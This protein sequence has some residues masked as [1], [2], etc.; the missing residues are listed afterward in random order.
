METINF[1]TKSET[2]LATI[3]VNSLD[4]VVKNSNLPVQEADEIKKSYLPFLNQLTETQ[5]QAA[6]INFENPT[7]LDENIAHELRM[8]TVK[9]RTGAEKLKEER[10]KMY[11]LR[12]NLEQASFNLIASSCKIIEEAFFNVE[13]AR[14]I[15]EKKRKEELRRDRSEKLS[16]YIEDVAL[17]PL[18]EMSEEQF[19]NLYSTLRAAHERQIEEERKAESERQRIAAEKAL[20]DERKNSILNFWQFV[21]EDERQSNFGT[22]DQSKWD[23]FCQ[24]LKDKKNAYDA[25]QERIRKDNERLAEEAKKKQ[26]ELEATLKRAKEEQEAK[27]K[28]MAEERRKAEEQRK[29]LEA[30]AAKER[31]EKERLEAELIAKREAEEKAKRDEE[32]RKKEAEKKARLAPDKDKLISFAQSIDDLPRPEIKAIEA[33]TIIANANTLLCKVRDYVIEN[34][35]KL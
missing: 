14:E 28:A 24:N 31:E 22:W 10:K 11:L 29:A 13:K 5:S 8:R 20:H 25:E 18:G 9:I 30:K 16:P 2:G 27:D 17:Y 3:D 12:G 6:K 7:E 19:S 32:R 23:D 35:S 1:E 15:A 34:A 21:P 33:A 4:A 26:A